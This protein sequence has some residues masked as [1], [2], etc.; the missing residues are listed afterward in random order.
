[1]GIPD[2]LRKGSIARGRKG[3][4]ASTQEVQASW[5]VAAH[6]FNPST[7]EAEAGGSLNLKPA[8]STE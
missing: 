1:M 7:V 4:R 6:A 3:L 5:V 2:V 8:W